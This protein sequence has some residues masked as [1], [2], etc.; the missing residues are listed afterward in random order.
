MSNKIQGRSIVKTF[1]HRA[2]SISSDWAAFHNEVKRIK[3]VS[4]LVNNNFSFSMI[5]KITSNFINTKMKNSN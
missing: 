5:D 3:Q 1:L 2:Y 4:V